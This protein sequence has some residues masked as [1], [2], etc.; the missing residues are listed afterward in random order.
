MKIKSC[1]ISFFR[2]IIALKTC[3]KPVSPLHLSIYCC[4]CKSV[5][6]PVIQTR[7]DQFHLKLSRV[8][9]KV[10]YKKICPKIAGAASASA[11]Q[12]AAAAAVAAAAAA[13]SSHAARYKPTKPMRIASSVA[14]APAWPSSS[15][16]SCEQHETEPEPSSSSFKSEKS[17][18]DGDGDSASLVSVECDFFSTPH[19]PPPAVVVSSSSST[20]VV[21]A[22]AGGPSFQLDPKAEND[23]EEGAERKPGTTVI[24][25]TR[26][27]HHGSGS[28]V[29]SV[30]GVSYVP[31]YGV[32]G[33]P[34]DFELVEPNI[35]SSNDCDN[36]FVSCQASFASFPC[37]PIL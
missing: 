19:S 7:N 25:V 14:P 28:G 5:I 17:E 31:V 26:D 30:D 9:G 27:P 29:S 32:S 4:T 11:R 18:T 1:K 2:E 21:R 20:T 33:V 24:Q 23:V 36:E 12:A 10:S 35:P 6:G 13:A 8:K 3:H 15:G 34:T 16:G 37:A 22:G